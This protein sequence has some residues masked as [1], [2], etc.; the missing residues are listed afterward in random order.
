MA[1]TCVLWVSG[2]LSETIAV[3]E[4]SSSRSAISSI[5]GSATVRITRSPMRLV[6][7]P[8]TIS[9]R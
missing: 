1:A 4:G 3:A 9:S 5:W 2:L 7:L 6:K 8:V